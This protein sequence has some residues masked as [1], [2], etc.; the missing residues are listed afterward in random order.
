[1]GE[2]IEIYGAKIVVPKR[3]AD[4]FIETWGTSD[5]S[6]QYWRRVGLPDYFDQ[7]KF[8]REGNA[9]LSSQQRRYAAE[10]VRRCKEGFWFMN[11]GQETYLTGKNYF[12]IQWWKLEND[13]Y[14]DFRDTDRRY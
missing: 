13:V 7:V 6:E 12:Y 4:T 3:S 8:D 10:E 5:P 1:M 11:N 14:P 2:F 9:D